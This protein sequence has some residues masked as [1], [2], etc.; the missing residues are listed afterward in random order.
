MLPEKQIM[1]A[2]KQVIYGGVKKVVRAEYDF[3]VHGGAASTI[4]LGL[5]IP[6]NS[7]VTK[8]LTDE[9]TAMAGG[10]SAQFKAAST[11]LTAAIALNAFTGVDNHALNGSVDGIKLAAKSEI[12]ITL[13]GTFTAGHIDIFIEYFQ[14]RPAD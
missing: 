1:A 6:A 2:C 13:V 3:S 14:G 9:R 5:T 12:K 7:I 11:A 4:S 8:V 10:T